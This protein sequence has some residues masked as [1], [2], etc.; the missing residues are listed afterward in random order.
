MHFQI[1]IMYDHPPAARV[2][3]CV[4]CGQQFDQDIYVTLKDQQF[5]WGVQFIWMGG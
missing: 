5:L 3:A 4:D 1:H 2:R